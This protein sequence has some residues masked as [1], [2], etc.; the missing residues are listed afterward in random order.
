MKKRNRQIKILLFYLFFLPLAGWAQDPHL[1]QFQSAPLWLNPAFTGEFGGDIRFVANY[2]NQWA[3]IPAPY[4]TGMFSVDTKIQVANSFSHFGVGASFYRDGAGDLDFNTTSAQLSV[5]YN[6][7]LGSQ[8]NSDF[9][10]YLGGQYG[11][12][13]QSFDM[14]K[15]VL[16]NPDQET[17]FDNNIGYND[18]SVGFVGVWVM[19]DFF[20]HVGVAYSHLNTPETSFSPSEEPAP[21]DVFLHSK[22]VYHCAANFNLKNNKV[23]LIPAVQYL[24]QHRQTA[25]IVG[26][27]LFF[28]QLKQKA[29]SKQLDWG[30][31][32]HHRWQDAVILSTKFRL[33]QQYNLGISYDLPISQI[34]QPS[35]S[36]GGVEI[37]MSFTIPPKFKQGDYPRQGGGLIDLKCP[38]A[39][40]RPKE[41]NPWFRENGVGL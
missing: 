22:Q 11:R 37:F 25:L 8:A 29:S 31:G 34:N 27:D 2:R 15:A 26:T 33:A 19:P 10:A 13:W 41:R 17:T 3:S 36:Y 4:N 30:I 1:S 35:N 6:M 18:F 28:N 24:R 39:G 16:E 7:Y 38:S 21:G 14:T 9:Y 40:K 5:A 32:V 12:V 23:T 20:V